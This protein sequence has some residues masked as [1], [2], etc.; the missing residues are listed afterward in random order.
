MCGCGRGGKPN[1]NRQYQDLKLQAPA[2]WHS[3]EQNLFW[4]GAFLLFG[5]LNA[6]QIG[7]CVLDKLR[8]Q[9]QWKTIQN[10]V[11][12]L[13][14]SQL[15][16]NKTAVTHFDARNTGRT[17]GRTI[18]HTFGPNSRPWKRSQHRANK[19]IVR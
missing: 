13:H 15:I 9:I 11:S 6:Q 16:C 18:V 3:I 4:A 12:K 19:R 8:I 2:Q 1:A 7:R 17:D 5:K 14:N 10:S